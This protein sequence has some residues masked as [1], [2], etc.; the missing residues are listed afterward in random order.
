MNANKSKVELKVDYKTVWHHIMIWENQ[1]IT[2]SKKDT[3]GALYF[4]SPYMEAGYSF[5]EEILAQVGRRAITPE[6]YQT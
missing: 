3:H 6:F 4:L 2:S 1:L 5:L